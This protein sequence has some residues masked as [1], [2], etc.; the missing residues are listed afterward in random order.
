MLE[1]SRTSTGQ[2]PGPHAKPP[3]PQ[4]VFLIAAFAAVLGVL[5]TLSFGY[6]DHDPKPHD[7]RLAVVAPRAVQTKLAAKL[8]QAAPGGFTLVSEPS[9]GAASASVR[10]QST[11]GALVVS[12]TGA[13]TVLSAGAQGTLESQTIVKT[14]TAAATASGAKLTSVDVAPLTHGDRA[15]L[16]AFVFELGLLIPSVIG[17]VGL[18]IVGARFRLWWRVAG[19]VF[20]ALLAGLGGTLV[21][22]AILGTLTGNGA[23]LV[24]IGFLG[25]VSFVLFVAACQA[26]VGLPGTALAALAFVFTGN[27]ISGGSVP[28]S[29]LPDGFR[30]IAPWLPN[31]A[32]VR[33]ARDV[34]YYHG[35]DLGHPLLVLGLWPAVALIVLAGVD[36]LHLRAR[37]QTPDRLE[38]V[39]STSGIAHLRGQL[40][41]STPAASKLAISACTAPTNPISP[42]DS[43][44]PEASPRR[45]R[46]SSSGSRPSSVSTAACAGSAE[47]CPANR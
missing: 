37:G 32:I 42:S 44:A 39:Y 3:A 2:A 6:A 21:M 10:A 27:A 11:A 26:L 4:R 18:F 31:N 12:D 5:I 29:F 45:R 25:A 1:D 47:R 19:A 15:G 7:V 24:G 35:T 20:F 9:A 22:D 33:G 30:Q 16:G 28:V 46:R 14:L 36:I 40:A 41:R 23:A 13:D 17:S 43:A 8:A 38:Q 34:I